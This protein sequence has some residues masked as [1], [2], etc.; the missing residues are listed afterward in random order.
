MPKPKKTPTRLQL[1]TAGRSACGLSV[2]E[3]A[4]DLGVEVQSIYQTIH[5]PQKSKRINAAIEKVIR[6]GRSRMAAA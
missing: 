5:F 3:I 1:F 4:E 2:G 6:E